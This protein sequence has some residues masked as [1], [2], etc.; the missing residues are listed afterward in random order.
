[1]AGS[2]QGNC[3]N[4]SKLHRLVSWP[5]GIAVAFLIIPVPRLIGR[6]KDDRQP[7]LQADQLEGEWWANQGVGTLGG[8]T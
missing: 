1:M 7:Y 5:I 6:G 4:Q 8:V 2:E 3:A